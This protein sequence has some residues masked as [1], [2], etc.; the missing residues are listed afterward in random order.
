MHLAILASDRAVGVD[1]YR[2]LVVNARCAP[3][4][5]RGD[6][7]DLSA[8]R[9]LSQRIGARSGNRLGKLEVTMILALA[10]VFRAKQLLQADDLRAFFCCR[11]DALD[12]SRQIAA[13]LSVVLICTKTSSRR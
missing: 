1:N 13:G 2:G 3:F 4:K 6:D 8:L 7:D 9:Q 11:F 12:R 10:K 5:K